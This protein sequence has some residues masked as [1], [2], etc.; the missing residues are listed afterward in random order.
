MNTTET[1]P[2]DYA[3]MVKMVDTGDLKSPAGR[4]V[5]SSPALPSDRKPSGTI[6]KEE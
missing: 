1:C 5:G 4:R 6:N 2:N 3:R